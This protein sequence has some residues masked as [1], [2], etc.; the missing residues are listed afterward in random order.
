M[1][2]LIDT[3]IT[4]GALEGEFTLVE[5]VDLTV[6]SRKCKQLAPHLSWLLFQLHLIQIL[7]CC[8]VTQVAVRG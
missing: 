5:F 1:F 6:V 8:E 2:R 7:N 3:L 4:I